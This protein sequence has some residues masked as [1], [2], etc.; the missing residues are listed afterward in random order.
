MKGVT[1]GNGAIVGSLSVVTKNVPPYAIVVGS[2]AQFIKWRHP[3]DIATHLQALAWWDWD[4]ATLHRAL[5]D[6][7]SLSAEAFL[8]R[9]EPLK[10]QKAG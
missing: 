6:F 4:H 3:E 5:P 9:Y 7:R 10:L 8:E 1:I 2:P